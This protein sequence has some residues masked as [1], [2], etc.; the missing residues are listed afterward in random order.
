MNLRKPV[1]LFL[2]V[3][4]ILVLLASCAI[5][6]GPTGGKKDTIPPKVVSELP[7]NKSL[8][9]TSDKITINFDEFVDLGDVFK[10]VIISPTLPKMPEILANR[11]SIT[12]NFRKIKLQPNTTYSIQFGNAIKDLN[13]GNVLR[14][15]RYVFSTGS[16]LDSLYITG[17]VIEALSR[18]PAL[19]YKIELYKAGN[20]SDIYKKKPL[21]YART[22]SSGNYKL[23]YLPKGVYSL[24]ALNDKNDNYFVDD[25]EEIGYPNAP[26]TLD[27][28]MAIKDTIK[29]FPFLAPSLSV[30][31]IS[32]GNHLL[33]VKFDKGVDSAFAMV[34]GN[35]FSTHFQTYNDAK[36]SFAWWMSEGFPEMSVRAFFM[37]TK[38]DTT[39]KPDEHPRSSKFKYE[40][41]GSGDNGNLYGT[42]IVV[43]ANKPIG[44]I[45]L[46]GIKVYKDSVPVKDVSVRYLDSAHTS[47]AIV[48]NSEEIA[49]K[50]KIWP[51]SVVALFGDKT[52]DTVQNIVNMPG[53][54]TTGYFEMNTFTG[55]GNY[56]FQLINETGQVVFYKN[57]SRETLV[58]IPFVNPGKY[59]ARI[60]K[61]DNKNGKWDGGD[62]RKRTQAEDVYYYKEELNIKA[63]WE[64]VGM[65]FDIYQKQAPVKKP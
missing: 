51:G 27:S 5:M 9:F 30:K 47:F 39:V 36:D 20:D 14:N 21:Y 17:K 56:I 50:V 40:I 15:Y 48:F 12:I 53:L 31:K 23:N 1:F 59:R 42:S 28:A 6:S 13:E 37:G 18:K 64:L 54:R 25:P 65:K 38:I 52:K 57:V 11:R 60:I 49:Y 4:A 44:T 43:R 63:N 24:Y 58:K 26:I 16:Y 22:D 32:L 19:G 55:S 3:I 8:N 46:A 61:D 2:N 45:S 35:K 41:S 33:Q 34:S 7:A 62:L 10:E 29:A